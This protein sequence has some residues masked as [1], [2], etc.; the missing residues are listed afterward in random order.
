MQKQRKRAGQALVEFALFITLLFTILSIV[1]DLG[2]AFFA[3][4]GVAGAAQEG[5]AYAGKWGRGNI[6]DP[7]IN[8]RVAN[9]GGVYRLNNDQASFV[10]LHDLNNDGI[11][12]SAAV[13]D[14]QIDV[15]IA[16]SQANLALPVSRRTN[17]LTVIR[18]GM[19]D[20]V[21]QVRYVY[22]PI[23]ALAAT[24]GKSSLTIRATRQTLVP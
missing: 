4:Q 14:A 19:C 13:R 2:L 11:R 1:I 5:A 6:N 15:T 16:S 20:V 22:K 9:E 7:E 18:P 21:V 3:Y 10:N 8:L 23:F 24:L 17:C 12:D